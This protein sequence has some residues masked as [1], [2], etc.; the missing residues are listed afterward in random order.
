[1]LRLKSI[2]IIISASIISLC[3]LQAAFAQNKND[4][5]RDKIEKIKLEKM[6]KKMDLDESTAEIFKDRYK[7]FSKTLRELNHKRAKAYLQMTQNIESG[8]GLDSLLDEVLSL[9]NQIDQERLNFVT[10]L[11]SLLTSKQIA[12]MIVFE[13]KFNNQLKKLLQNYR[14]DNKQKNENN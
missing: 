11:K 7:T 2:L 5:I 12:T 3:S 6:V 10:D 9:E 13:R 14:K 4:D 1:M 8:N